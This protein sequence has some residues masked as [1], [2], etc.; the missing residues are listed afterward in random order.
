MI[1]S[2][3]ILA[4]PNTR[5]NLDALRAC[6]Q[7]LQRGDKLFRLFFYNDGVYSANPYAVTPQ[8]EVDCH[9]AWTALINNHTLDAVVCVA[10]ASR[11]GLHDAKGADKLKLPAP[12]VLPPF[13]IAGLGEWADALQ[14]SDQILTFSN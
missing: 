1:T 4:A 13:R 12:N 6:T 2:V 9:A 14:A 5:A 7:H 10:S 8:G 11:R 3:L